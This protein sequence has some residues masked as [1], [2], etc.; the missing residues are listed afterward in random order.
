[1]WSSDVCSS[2]LLP[3]RERLRHV[4]V[5]AGVQRGDLLFLVA[6]GGDEDNRRVGPGA[7]LAR[8]VGAG[9]VGQQQVEHDRIRRLQAGRGERLLR[10]GRGRYLVARALEVR[11]ER[12]QE[13]R[14]VV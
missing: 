10:G 2:D 8:H 13:L 14:L 9:A 12:A 3:G 1:D 6:D 4:V 11:R 7:Q 5:G